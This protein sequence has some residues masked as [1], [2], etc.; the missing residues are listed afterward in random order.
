[1]PGASCR[2]AAGRRRRY[3][4]IEAEIAVDWS[5][6][7]RQPG[8]VTALEAAD[9]VMRINHAMVGRATVGR[10]TFVRAAVGHGA[11]G[12]AAVGHGRLGDRWLGGE[13]WARDGPACEGPLR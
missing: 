3:Q 10:A 13:S 8:V 2:A 5:D 4:V 1:M 12:H 9:A 6:G 11:V 7:R